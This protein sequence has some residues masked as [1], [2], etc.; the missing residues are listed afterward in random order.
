MRGHGLCI[1]TYPNALFVDPR[2]PLTA[3]LMQCLASG[4]VLAP[5]V[6]GV[7]ELEVRQSETAEA[8]SRGLASGTVQMILSESLPLRP[9]SSYYCCASN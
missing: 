8:D 4:S 1:R 3:K 7:T 9:V 5:S 6:T 2:C